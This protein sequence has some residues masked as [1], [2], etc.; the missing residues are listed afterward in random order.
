MIVAVIT[1]LTAASG[2]P[3][4]N[5]AISVHCS[6]GVA[7]INRFVRLAPDG[8][9]SQSDRGAGP[10]VK[11]GHM[12]PAEARA[13]AARLDKV[14]FTT[15]ASLPGN[16]QIRDGID[17][18]ITRL[19]PRSHTVRLPAGSRAGNR[20]TALRYAEVRLIMSIIFNAAD[21]VALNPQPIPP[22]EVRIK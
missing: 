16:T 12:A 20:Y 5:A 14:S 21:R 3:D 11:A 18:A 6:G 2:Q 10:L 1:L 7:G 15:L 19:G 22:D 13:L 8:Q 17:C 9:L 4:A